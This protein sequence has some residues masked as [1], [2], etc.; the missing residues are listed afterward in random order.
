MKPVPIEVAGPTQKDRSPQL[1]SQ[2]TMNMY[3][4]P[5]RETKWAA[6][7]FPGAKSF[8]TRSGSD[9]GQHVF[10]DELYQVSG[11]QLLR[12]E[13]DGTVLSLGAI[14]G[15]GR[16]VF[17][18][19]GVNLVIV[20]DGLV[21][22]YDGET[23]ERIG[24]TNLETPNS[25]AY[26]NGYFLYDGDEGR[27]QASDAG[28]PATINDLSVG[29]A[30]SDG[31]R[32]I[33]GYVHNQVVWWMGPRALEPWYFSGS[34]DL[35]FERLEQ[36]IVKRG[37]GACYS[38]ASNDEAIFFLG[39][40]RQVYRLA[41]SSAQNVTSGSAKAI[42]NFTTIDDAVAWLF[43]FDSQEFYLLTFPTEGKTLLHSVTYGYWVNLSSGMSEGR[44]I[45]SSGAYCY[46][47]N[48]IADYRSGNLY[49][50]D[51]ETY[52]DNGEARL[53][54]RDCAP[55]T[56]RQLGIPGRRIL[57]GRLQLDVEMGVGLASGQGVDPRLLCRWSNDGGKTFGPETFTAIGAMGDY[58]RRVDFDAFVDGYNLVAR[59]G[60]SDPVYFSLFGGIAEVADGGH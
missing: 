55:I 9:R 56:G 50:L 33:R 51:G 42:E 11:G 36:G 18:D 21:S 31:D 24:S 49:E 4:A 43:T 5:G 47:K 37:L 15:N 52:T 54:Y 32:L 46:G 53:R 59:I 6:Y 45:A 27:F 19:D 23:V 8:V 29:V 25:V 2:M 60:C 13:S 58:D 10:N 48:I 1:S 17:A 44:H 41:Q 7:D 39:S 30:N 12:I 26:L 3:L 28:D 57:C 22:V 38:V 40:D 14:P 20:S 35:P 16:C 34:G